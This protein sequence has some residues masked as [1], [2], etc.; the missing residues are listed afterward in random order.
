[1][2]VFARF[3]QHEESH[4]FDSLATQLIRESFEAQ[5][6]QYLSQLPPSIPA[7]QYDQLLRKGIAAICDLHHYRSLHGL[8]LQ[9]C[10]TIHPITDLHL[11]AHD[12]E[13]VRQLLCKS[14][15]KDTWDEA[16][17]TPQLLNLSMKGMGAFI[18]HNCMNHSCDPNAVT[19]S[20]GSTH[21]VSV[22]NLKSPLIPNTEL[23]I[24]YIDENL[25]RS[26][27]QIKLQQQYLFE[28]MCNKCK[29]EK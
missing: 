6:P 7:Q 1:M 14:V 23:T 24:S 16:V 5:L 13:S 19:V 25:A 22:Y 29:Q 21:H 18:I 20:D 9:N 26:E 3:V 27:R 28:C 17:K 11:V 12:N 10:S 4:P 2:H 8:I 15:S